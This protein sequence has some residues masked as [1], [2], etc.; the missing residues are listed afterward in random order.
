MDVTRLEECEKSNNVTDLKFDCSGNATSRQSPSEQYWKYNV[1]DQSESISDIG[2]IKLDLVLFLAFAYF[3][4]FVSLA[5]VRK[6]YQGSGR[7][8]VNI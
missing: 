8:T 1:L 3:I 6:G 4:L 7:F 2:S 5:K